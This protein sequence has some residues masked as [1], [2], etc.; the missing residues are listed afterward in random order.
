ME[1][2]EPSSTGKGSWSFLA[3]A[4]NLARV[5][6]ELTAGGVALSCPALTAFCRLMS[7]GSVIL[8]SQTTLLLFALRRRFQQSIR[9]KSLDER[10]CRHSGQGRFLL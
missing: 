3:P 1:P 7:A 6:E 8:A 2:R 10:L 5:R 4:T 9:G